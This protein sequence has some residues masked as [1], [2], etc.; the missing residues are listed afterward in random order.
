[1]LHT[2]SSINTSCTG[3][4]VHLQHLE[5][6]PGS[7]SNSSCFVGCRSGVGPDLPALPNLCWDKTGLTC[8]LVPELYV[9][10]QPK[11]PEHAAQGSVATSQVPGRCYSPAA[12][13]TLY[14]CR[15]SAALSSRGRLALCL[16]SRQGPEIQMFVEL[17]CSPDGRTPPPSWSRHLQQRPPCLG[18]G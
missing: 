12:A 18:R 9:D 16:S 17:S 3:Y 7:K 4:L 11:L 10:L 13:G 14:G 15:R 6:M 5:Q 2:W 8:T 1:M